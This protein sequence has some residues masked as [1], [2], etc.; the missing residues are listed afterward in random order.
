APQESPLASRSYALSRGGIV[1]TDF[2]KDGE[3]T[4][5][6]EAA[7]LVAEAFDFKGHEQAL[8][9][10]SAPGGKTIQIAEHLPDGQVTA[11]EIHEKKLRLVKENAAR[12]RVAD[13]VKVKAL[14]A[15]KAREYFSGQEFDKI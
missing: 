9:A 8:D 12:M 10:C 14:D 6:D 7:S 2:F 4:V 15:R 11:L 3:V 1:M 13:R 5:Q